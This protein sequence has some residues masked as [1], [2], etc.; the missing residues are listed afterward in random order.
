LAKTEPV[1]IAQI[2]SASEEHLPAI[3]KLAGLIWREYYPSIITPEQIEYMLAAMYSLEKLR[4]ELRDGIRYERLLVGGEL[5]GFASFGETEGAGEFKLHKLYLNP[6]K[7]GRGLGSLLLAH[8][9]QEAQKLGAR[10]LILNVN[11][12]N[13][14]AIA[15]Y[16]KNG[17]RITDSV[18][19]DIG[20]GFVMDDYVMAKP[21]S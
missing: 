1:S 14:K 15:V 8:C 18:V 20:N 21:L 19:L 12:R 11:K 9:E 10:R 13:A 16:Q 5:A 7:H 2:V 3:S 4:T 6:A 17:F